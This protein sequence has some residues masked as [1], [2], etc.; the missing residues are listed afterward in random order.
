MLT[1]IEQFH[2]WKIPS[3]RML[4]VVGQEDC[5]QS[6]YTTYSREVAQWLP[7]D[8]ALFIYHQISA[9]K[10]SFVYIQLNDEDSNLE[11]TPAVEFKVD[12]I[13]V[14]IVEY[15]S[16]PLP[17][18]I[19]K[20]KPMNQSMTIGKYQLK[21]QESIDINIADLYR[22]STINPESTFHNNPEIRN[23]LIKLF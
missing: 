9:L 8:I 19:L 18:A 16:I 20:G 11:Q 5:I 12:D 13:S 3:K 7:N 14:I 10:G 15:M 22:L 23:K 21:C 4:N 6:K 1:I 17:Q 2:H